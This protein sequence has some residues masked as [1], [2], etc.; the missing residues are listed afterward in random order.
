[1]V[2]LYL[3]TSIKV[4]RCITQQYS[5]SFYSAVSLLHPSIRDH[6]YAVYGFVRLADEVVD[7]FQGYPQE[8]LFDELTQ[9]LDRAFERGISTNPVVHAFVQVVERCD[10]DRSLVDSFLDSM[11]VDLWRYD[12]EEAEA[13]EHYI[14]GSAVVVGLI[15]LKIFTHD[16][17][18]LYNE[19]KGSAAA[20]G[21]AFQK[22]NFLRDLREDYMD[23][24]RNYFPEFVQATFNEYSK[25]EIIAQIETEFAQA[26][27]G[28]V[29]LPSNSRLG[30]YVAYNY[31]LELL[32]KIKRSTINELL[33]QRVRVNNLHKAYLLVHCF[34]HRPHKRDTKR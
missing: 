9:E 1:M 2:K 20:L 32:H 18:W 27:E 12:Y 30:V 25:A 24:H 26:Y 17:P 10:I 7:S 33:H 21:S 3:E 13:I 23:L 22:V 31:Y 34:W 6:I 8:Q 4:S 19:L 5:T 14:Y 29:R 16:Q 15:C 11:R 28:I